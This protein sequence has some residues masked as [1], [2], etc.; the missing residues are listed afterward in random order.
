MARP[1]Q[2]RS[3]RVEDNLAE[4]IAYER[5]RREWS[6]EALA[7]RMTEL[8][9]AIH[10]SALFKIEKGTKGDSGK[11]RRIT[12]DELMGLALA[13]DLPP[14]NLLITPEAVGDLRL[15]E[16]L[17]EA[18]RERIQL[19]Y[20]E[21]KYNLK[22]AQIVRLCTDETYGPARLENIRAQRDDLAKELAEADERYQA[23]VE[24]FEDNEASENDLQVAADASSPITGKIQFLD[25]VLDAMPEPQEAGEA[26]E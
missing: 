25:A 14:E 26:D 19:Q 3:I 9:C 22:I 20:I 16:L 7:T 8:G 2:P 4:R 1:N 6:Y 21:S 5:Q 17:D 23:T 18:R 24:R 12:V 13:F 10:A 11:R 15:R